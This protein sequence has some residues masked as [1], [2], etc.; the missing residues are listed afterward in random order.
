[1]KQNCNFNTKKET[2]RRNFLP[3]YVLMTRNIISINTNVGGVLFFVMSLRTYD[4]FLLF[5]PLYVHRNKV[6]KKD[7]VKIHAEVTNREIHPNLYIFY[8][9]TWKKTVFIQSIAND[10]IMMNGWKKYTFYIFG[11]IMMSKTVNYKL[12]FVL[13]TLDASNFTQLVISNF[14]NNLTSQQ[15]FG[16]I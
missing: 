7:P 12:S 1:M 9:C 13:V 5:F 15:Y 8:L 3:F 10:G 11:G 16:E 6:I 14:H 2:C 4:P